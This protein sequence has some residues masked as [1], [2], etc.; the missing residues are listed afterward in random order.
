[1]IS[2]VVIGARGYTGA[3]LL[4]LL[5]RH[6]EFEIVAVGSSSAAGQSVNEHVAVFGNALENRTDQPVTGRPAGYRLGFYH[7]GGKPVTGAVYTP[8]CRHIDSQGRVN[9]R[10]PRPAPCASGVTANLSR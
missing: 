7:I 2:V 6:P 10:A 3:E 5:Y 8:R 4:P 1:M 9:H